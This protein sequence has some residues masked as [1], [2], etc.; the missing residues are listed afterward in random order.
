LVA[1][2]VEFCF[3]CY[4]VEHLLERCGFRVVELFGNS[5]GSPLLNN[6]P[7]MIFVAEKY[8]DFTDGPWLPEASAGN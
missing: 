6:S 3:F 8:K 1:A 2:W 5:D 4:E 7:E